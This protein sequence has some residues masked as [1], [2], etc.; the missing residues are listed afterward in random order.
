[1]TLKDV[2][3]D[4]Y[5][6]AMTG[7]VL[8]I[9]GAAL[10]IMPQY[11]TQM[12][13]AVSFIGLVILLGSVMIMMLGLQIEG[14]GTAGADES[15]DVMSAI[16]E[17]RDQLHEKMDAMAAT[18]GLASSDGDSDASDDDDDEAADGE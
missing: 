3:G 7:F 4:G 14:V 12:D 5:K 16:T 15:F 10:T 1:M 2:L 6:Q 18:V 11:V 13:N 9:V 8:M 17:M